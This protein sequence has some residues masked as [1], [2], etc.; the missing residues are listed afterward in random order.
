M[1]RIGW[2][3]AAPLLFIPVYVAYWINLSH[4]IRDGLAPWAAARQAEGLEFAWQSVAVEG[5]PFA[6]RLHFFG[7]ALRADHPLPYSAKSPELLVWSAPWRLRLWQFDAPQGVEI[8]SP[9]AVAGLAIGALKGA[10]G[11]AEPRRLDLDG[12]AI[13]G[14]GAAGGIAA[15]QAELH[16][17]LPPKAPQ[18]HRDPA[19]ALKAELQHARLPLPLP[20]DAREIASL[21][22]A[23]IMRGVLPPGSLEQS[24]AAWRNDGGTLDLDELHSVWGKVTADIV[25]T[26]AL[27]QA[28]QPTGAF[29]ATIAGADAAIDAMAASGV[30]EARYTGIAKAILRAI[31]GPQDADKPDAPLK[32]P[33]TIQDSRVYLGPA[34]IARLPHITWR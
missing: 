23:A 27:D 19:F 3:L 15:A 6:V 21:S 14:R 33:L 1:R 25:G 8:A 11:T 18:D 7:V 29:T 5:F 2:V 22:V 26:L 4:Q 20:A 30:L 9:G 10:V 13:A 17:T 32:V 31:A 12:Q 28:M 16:L 34:E 24:L